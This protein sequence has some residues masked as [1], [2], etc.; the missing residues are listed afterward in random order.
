MGETDLVDNVALPHDDQLLEHDENVGAGLM[1]G[2]QART[3]L[4]TV[5]MTSSF[6]A[7]NNLVLQ[8]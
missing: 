7:A 6:E 2:C 1:D 8:L 5:S 4:F 3:F